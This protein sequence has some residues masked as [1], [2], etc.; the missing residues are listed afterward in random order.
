MNLA[1]LQWY[2]VIIN[3]CAFLIYTIDFQI[4]MHGGDGIRPA[5]LCN[6]AT[7]CGGALGTLAAEILWDR[8]INKRNAQS[9]IYTLVWLILQ[10]ALFWAM[11]G[12]NHAAAREHALSFYAEHRMLCLYY[13]AI[14]II[15]F[16]LFAVDKIKALLKAWRIPEVA[17]LGLCLAGGGAGGLLAMDI[18]NHKV[19]SRHFIVGVPLMLCAH[20]ILLAFV[21]AGII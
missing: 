12:P 21:I 6:L 15:T 9:R 11:W 10:F 13:A 14:N 16:V 5:V 20:L 17:L 7:I 19:H 2:V 1:P 4:Y 8:R 3:L 18:C